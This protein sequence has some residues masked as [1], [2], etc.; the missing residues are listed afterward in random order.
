[1]SLLRPIKRAASG[2]QGAITQ[3]FDGAYWRERPGYINTTLSVKKGKRASFSGGRYRTD[4]HLAI[5]YSAAIGSRLYA[6]HAGKIIKQGVDSTGGKF[7]YL[8][9]KRSTTHQLVV[10][11]YHLSGFA[12]K[13]GDTVAKGDLI[14]YSGNTGGTSTGG[15]LHFELMKAPR[16]WTTGMMYRSAMRFDPQPFI[17]GRALRDLL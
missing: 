14:G 13:T 12:R 8:R 16:W 11:Y 3:D 1:L 7:I 4:L 17:N 6:V 15:H 10:L 9:V 5:D 2:S